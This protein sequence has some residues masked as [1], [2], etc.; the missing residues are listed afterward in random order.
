MEKE[1]DVIQG[2]YSTAEEQPPADLGDLYN[3]SMFPDQQPQPGNYAN[4]IEDSV[5]SNLEHFITMPES[6]YHTTTAPASQAFSP[7][8]LGSIHTISSRQSGTAVGGATT[9]FSEEFPDFTFDEPEFGSE[10][11]DDLFGEMPE[12]PGLDGVIDQRFLEFLDMQ[13]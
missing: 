3:I 6:G 7:F 8:D 1:D 12:M 4:T 2:V 13:Q 11:F 5:F 10:N 9:Q